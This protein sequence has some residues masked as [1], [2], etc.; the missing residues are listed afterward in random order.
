MNE[1]HNVMKPGHL[2]DSSA[3]RVNIRAAQRLIRV[4]MH[5]SLWCLP[6]CILFNSRGQLMLLLIKHSKQQLISNEQQTVF[7]VLQ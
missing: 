1:C 6:F 4:N 2:Q 7:N 5:K 3:E